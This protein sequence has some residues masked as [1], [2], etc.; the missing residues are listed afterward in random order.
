[1]KRLLKMHNL[2]AV[3]DVSIGCRITLMENLWTEQGLPNG[4]FGTMEDILVA[5]SP[6]LARSHHMPFSFIS[7]VMT[8]P[9]PYS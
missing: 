2:K 9:I 1:M 7:I 6:T 3:L 4:A 5:R 8:A